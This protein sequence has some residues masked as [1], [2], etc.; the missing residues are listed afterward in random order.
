MATIALTTPENPDVYENKLRS[1]MIRQ[2]ITGQ[3][4]DVLILPTT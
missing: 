2:A 3:V 1:I 4:A